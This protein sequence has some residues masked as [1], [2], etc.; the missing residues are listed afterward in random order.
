MSPRTMAK[1]LT[2]ASILP[3]DDGRYS[4]A[5]IRASDGGDIDAERLRTE[6]AKADNLE[7]DAATKLGKLVDVAEFVRLYHTVLIAMRQRIQNEK[8]VREELKHDLLADL[9]R[10]QTESVEGK[11]KKSKANK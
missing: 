4:T 1:R 10:L 2:A 6:R 7:I 9:A 3:G 11:P 8:G 5:Q